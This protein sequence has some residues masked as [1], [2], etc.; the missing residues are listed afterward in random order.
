LH[1]GIYLRDQNERTLQWWAA[2]LK[3]VL[4]KATPIHSLLKKRSNKAIKFFR[5]NISF[6][7][8][9]IQ[10]NEK[11]VRSTDKG[12]KQSLIQQSL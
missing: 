12:I 10:K 7:D 3:N 2:I 4:I 8:E 9:A 1:P 6:L 11:N 5:P